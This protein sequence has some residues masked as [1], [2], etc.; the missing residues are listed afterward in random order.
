MHTGAPTGDQ[1]AL[2]E[3]ANALQR[4]YYVACKMDLDETLASEQGLNSTDMRVYNKASL[5]QRRDVLP[6][7]GD[8]YRSFLAYFGGYNP[9]LSTRGEVTSHLKGERI[10]LVDH[11]SVHRLCFDTIRYY[12]QD[13][14][15]RIEGL[16][17][18]ID[19]LIV[20]MKG[21]NR[22]FSFDER[23]NGIQDQHNVFHV[24][25]RNGDE[26]ILDVAGAQFG[27]YDPVGPY[28]QYISLYVSFIMRRKEFVFAQPRKVPTRWETL[29][30]ETLR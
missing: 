10:I 21:G 18:Q 3:A 11:L 2:F 30:L 17:V 19:E 27:L 16:Q 13:S 24:K 14:A 7:N 5:Q 29:N 26:Y 6:Q 8:E 28:Q 22:R 4:R 15:D 12:M 23:G 9:M 1:Q 20:V 25:L